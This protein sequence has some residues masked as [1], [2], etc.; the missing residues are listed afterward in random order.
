M[1]HFFIPT[2]CAL[3]LTLAHSATAQTSVDLPDVVTWSAYGQGS[4][5]NAQ[6]VAMGAAL[7]N[8]F[9][10][11]LR[12]LPGKNDVSRMI[13][14]RDQRV[15][16][17]A[18]GIA[19]YFAQEGIEQFNDREWGPQKIRVLIASNPDHNQGLAATQESGIASVADLKGKRVAAVVGSAAINNGVEAILA[20]AGLGWEDV[21]RVDFPGYAAS[22]SGMNSGQVD[23]AWGATTISGAYQLENSTRGITWIP[24]PQDDSEGWDRLQAKG[25]HIIPHIA[26]EG[27]GI[28]EDAP[29]E[30]T[31]YP[32]PV[33]IAYADQDPDLV[34][35]MTQ[36]LIDTYPVYKDAAPGADG[37]ALDKQSFDWIIPF[38]DGAVNAMKDAG[39][40]SDASNTYNVAL[41]E[42]QEKLAK[43]WQ[44]LIEQGLEGADLQQ[45]WL[46]ERS[47]I[48]M[49]SAE[50]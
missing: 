6:A 23:A 50:D 19:S 14:L 32:Y 3:G 48:P 46:E 9:G 15:M 21:E 41:I 36:A 20:F 49:P 35:S 8:E 27:A 38:H 34:Q 40:W 16:F 26:T 17:S 39:V 12:I 11:T 43:S 42:R 28:S 7:K 33:L 4:T 5:G 2:I 47:G 10:K 1:K 37:W 30:G 22:W 44:G 31:N 18:A 24:V 45:A 13:P 29:H 25:P